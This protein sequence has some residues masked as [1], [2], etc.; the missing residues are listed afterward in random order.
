MSA[1]SLSATKLE[2]RWLTPPASVLLGSDLEAFVCQGTYGRNR[3]PSLDCRLSTVA[4]IEW[5]ESLSHSVTYI[6]RDVTI[7]RSSGSYYVNEED[8]TCIP[9]TRRVECSRAKGWIDE[10]G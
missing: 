2:Y 7:L 8:I 4:S 9:H 3:E 1:C 10:A 5:D 6:Y